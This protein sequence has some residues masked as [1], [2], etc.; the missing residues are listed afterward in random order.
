MSNI[1]KVLFLLACFPLIGT[2]QDDPKGIPVDQQQ[3]GDHRRR[4][5]S[6][7]AP[8]SI[9]LDQTRLARSEG[10]VL[11][12]HP[13]IC[14]CHFSN[15]GSLGGRGHVFGDS[16]R[17]ASDLCAFRGDHCF[18][19]ER[20]TVEGASRPPIRSQSMIERFC[21]FSVSSM[22]ELDLTPG[23]AVPIHESMAF[24]AKSKRIDPWN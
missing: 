7:D 1:L 12:V 17:W 5:H 10:F 16:A 20:R 23:C 24:V 4:S 11:C 21:K 2:T 9:K 6:V 15:F 3:G 14:H 8:G 22:D 13:E 19:T 18:Y